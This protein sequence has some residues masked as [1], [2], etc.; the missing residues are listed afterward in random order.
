MYTGTIYVLPSQ[1]QGV[2]QCL[3][4]WHGCI[5]YARPP[6][7]CRFCCIQRNPHPEVGSF[8]LKLCVAA[9]VLMLMRTPLLPITL[10]GDVLHN[11]IPDLPTSDTYGKV[12]VQ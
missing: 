6:D 1:L 7:V 3:Q 4:T 5:T 8:V 11:Y 2:R 12:W 9:A 10:L